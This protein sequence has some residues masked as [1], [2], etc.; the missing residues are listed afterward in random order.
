ML[1]KIKMT[2]FAAVLCLFG[3]VLVPAAPAWAGQTKNVVMMNDCTQIMV[4]N[5]DMESAKDAINC[6]K[7]V[8]A[9]VIEEQKQMCSRLKQMT[10]VSVDNWDG[11]V[12]RDRAQSLSK[13]LCF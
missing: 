8:A 9:Q 1:K 6:Y 10:D 13:D 2:T 12:L 7:Y 5:G 3:F 11:V 4:K